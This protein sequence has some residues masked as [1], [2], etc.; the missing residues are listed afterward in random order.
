MT[1]GN[2]S[3]SSVSS[4]SETSSPDPT[5]RPKNKQLPLLPEDAYQDTQVSLPYVDLTVTPDCT[6]VDANAPASVWV[7]VCAT[8][9]LTSATIPIRCACWTPGASA[10]VLP[11]D[12]IIVGHIPSLKLYFKAVGHCR[13]LDIVGQKG[14]RDP[15]PG[16]S[17]S[18][19]VKVQ[20][21][22]IATYRAHKSDDQDSLFTEL[23]SIVGTLETDLLSVEVRYRHSLLPVNNVVTVRHTA[24]ICRAKANCRWSII[25]PE[26]QLAASLAVHSQLASY[27]AGHYPP[28]RAM[29][30]IERCLGSQQLE[31]EQVRRIYERL[32]E[33]AED[34]HPQQTPAQRSSRRG[35]HRHRLRLG[36][37][38]RGILNP[39]PARRTPSQSSARVPL[40]Y[41]KRPPWTRLVTGAP[42]SHKKSNSPNRKEE[43]KKKTTPPQT[44]PVCSSGTSGTRRSRPSNSPP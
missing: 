2:W 4:V 41:P 30:L 14:L 42:R 7:A 9:R 24:Q 18:I 35:R 39:H 33:E 16:T 17:C 44:Q 40:R 28:A 11:P 23:E 34:S 3:A 6:S 37:G 1:P 19:F 12:E 20:L 10:A 15:K 32:D 25:D 26:K 13:L 38:V 22:G 36:Q 29:N 5:P 43:N 31:H 8:V 21:P 27:L